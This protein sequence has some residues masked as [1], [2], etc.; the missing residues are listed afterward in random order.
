LPVA[1]PLRVHLARKTASM[2]FVTH[3]LPLVVSVIEMV[4]A[5]LKVNWAWVTGSRRG[6]K[7]RL[8]A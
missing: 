4:K 3:R 1:L 5:L 6:L 7:S 8:I 2:S